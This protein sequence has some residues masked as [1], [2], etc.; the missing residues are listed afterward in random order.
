MLIRTPR[1]ADKLHELT[2]SIFFVTIFWSFTPLF[3]SLVTFPSERAIIIKERAGGSY[4]LSAYFLAKVFS[5]LPVELA[6]PTAFI[7]LQYWLCGWLAT[8]GAFFFTLLSILLSCLCAASYGLLISCSLLDFK[9]AITFTSVS[10]LTIMLLSGF[11]VPIEQI[12]VWLRWAS[13]LGQSNK[14]RRR[15]EPLARFWFELLTRLSHAVRLLLSPFSSVPQ[16]H[17]SSRAPTRAR[18]VT[19]LCARFA[20]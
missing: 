14:S 15:A 3:N 16:V 11:Y 7:I 10:M 20:L 9:K 13:Y 12:P 8:P 18:R 19:L 1:R 17:V 4:R 2:G 5:E 6:Y